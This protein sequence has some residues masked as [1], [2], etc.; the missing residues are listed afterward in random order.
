MNIQGLER[1]AAAAASFLKALGNEKRLQILCRL[2]EGEL[3]VG[4]LQQAVGL[5][6]SALSQHL[7]RLRKDRLVLTRRE[8]Q[9]IY[10]SL[11]DTA[12]TEVIAVLHGRFC[13]PMAKRRRVQ[14]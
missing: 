9:T 10:Y 13:A 14:G 8:S 2:H 12:V 4:E 5:S 7:A 6:Q 1:N 3:S 11:A